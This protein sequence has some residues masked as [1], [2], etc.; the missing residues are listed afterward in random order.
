MVLSLQFRE[1]SAQGHG[2]GFDLHELGL[3]LVGS[4]PR[5]HG[6]DAL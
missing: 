3:V 1:P 5:D 6:P 4:R 2:L